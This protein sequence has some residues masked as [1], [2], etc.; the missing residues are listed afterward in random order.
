MVSQK[1]QYALRAVFELSKHYGKGPLK[2]A[3][4]AEEQAIPVRFLE[5]IL[6]QL[7]QGG[8]VESRRGREGGYL[9]SRAPGRLAVGDLIRFVEGPIGPVSCV[10]GSPTDKCP[11]HGGCVF[12][13]MW[14]RARRAVADVYD[15]TT[16]KDL[17]DEEKRAGRYV[18]SYAI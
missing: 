4:I 15:S 10:A 9:L 18:P 11:L 13:S 6:S 2:I 16:F 3:D 8:F 12:L 1:C 17:I 7:K 14:E 5:V